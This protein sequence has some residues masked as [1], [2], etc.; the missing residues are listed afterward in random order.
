MS[1]WWSYGPSDFLMFSA[2][3]WY[4]QLEL[5]NADWATPHVVAMLAAAALLGAVLGNAVLVAR[6]ALVLAGLAWLFVGW[7]FHWTRY[8]PINWAASYFAVA[9]GLQGLLLV[10]AG[11]AGR[12]PFLA[13]TGASGR[14]GSLML[15]AALLYPLLAL[16]LDRPL[17]QAEWF[18]LMPD[19][20]V[21]ATLG[22]LLCLCSTGPAWRL[23]RGL[24]M[25]LPLLWCAVTGA[26][27]WALH[28]PEW[29]LLPLAGGLA[30]VLA[31][32][33]RPA[34]R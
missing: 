33:L 17:S 28:A 32:W 12:Q 9:F 14:V 27:L 21:L 20:T 19:P 7:A 5:H 15:L 4:R 25:L 31:A 6:S 34:P 16:A 26:T 3:T 13:W 8:A 29:W 24:L 2:P 1:E 10:A 11:L 23:G 18:G 22:L 30:G